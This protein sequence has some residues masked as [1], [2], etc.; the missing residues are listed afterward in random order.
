MGRLTEIIDFLNQEEMPSTQYQRHFYTHI[1]VTD[2]L[3]KLRQEYRKQLK[4]QP[5]SIQLSLFK[6]E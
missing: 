3:K 4:Q 5:P 6:K 2:E 1:E